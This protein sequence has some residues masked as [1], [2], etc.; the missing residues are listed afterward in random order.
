M[1]ISFFNL[2]SRGRK[3]KNNPLYAYG[4][5]VG[6]GGLSEQQDDLWVYGRVDGVWLSHWVSK[7]VV[8][9]GV[10]FARS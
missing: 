9:G 2:L 7:V 8:E 1:D 10:R 4:K 6:Q 3:S 5:M